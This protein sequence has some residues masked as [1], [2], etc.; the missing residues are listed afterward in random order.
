MAGRSLWYNI[1]LC[2]H[3]RELSEDSVHVGSRAFAFPVAVVAVAMAI[4]KGDGA[5]SAFGRIG[6]HR[7]PALLRRLHRFSVARVGQCEICV[8]VTGGL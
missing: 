7:R 8:Q 1:C 3:L 2:S 5:E 6:L 4:E